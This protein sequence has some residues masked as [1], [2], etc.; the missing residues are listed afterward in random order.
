[1]R[2]FGRVS[3][4]VVGAA[5]GLC[6]LAGPAAAAEQRV[7]HGPF[8]VGQ[9]V[10]EGLAG[11]LEVRVVEGEAT[12]LVVSGP[13]EAVAALE[14]GAAADVLTVTAPAAGHSVTVVRQQTVVTG[15]G[16]SSSVVISGS[17]ASASG[18]AGAALDVVVDMPAGTGLVLRGFTGEAGIGDL[19]AAVAI[20]AVGGAVR[21]G[22]VT[23][24]DLAAIGGGRIEVAAVT[25]DLEA[26]VVGDG[27]IAVAAGGIDAARVEVTGAGSVVVEA[28]ARIAQVSIIGDGEVRFAEVAETPTVSRVGS[29]RFRVGPP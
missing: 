17:S 3:R 27:R 21:L 29:G 9:V 6:L 16:A 26:G 2:S 11:T 22:A 7:E 23:D 1:M 14:V 25:G 10:L 20:E 24:A 28:A 5:A 15:P 4:G 12:R 19:A 18:A 8:N 13:A